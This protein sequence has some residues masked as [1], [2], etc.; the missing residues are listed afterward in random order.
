MIDT[1]AAIATPAGKGGVA[2]VRVSGPSAYTVAKALLNK[3]LKPRVATH[4]PFYAADG[5]LLDQGIAI[6]FKAPHSFT[7][8]EVVEFHG[9]GGVI[10]VQQVLNAIIAMAD[11]RMARPGEFSERAFLN[12]KIDLLQAESIAD[13]IDAHSTQAARCAMQSLQGVF[14]TEIKTLIAQLI[15]LRKWVE[16]SIDFSDEDL[17]LMALDQMQENI[18]DALVQLQRIMSAA[19]Q[20]SVLRNGIEMVLLGAPNVGKS[21]VLNAL[22]GKDVAIVTPVSGTTR[23]V[24]RDNIE[25]DGLLF[26]VNDTAGIR[27]TGD[28]IE[29]EG[30]RR[31][32]Q[33]VKKSDVILVMQDA[34]SPDDSFVSMEDLRRDG[35]TVIKVYNKI[36]LIGEGPRVEVKDSVTMVFISAK[37]GEGLDLL[38]IQLKKAAGGEGGQEATFMARTRHLESLRLAESYLQ[39]ALSQIISQTTIDMVAEELRCGQEALNQII[40]EGFTT[41]STDTIL[42]D[43]F[44]SF[45]VG[46]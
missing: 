8:E 11:V 23:D 34:T 38:K 44:S 15:E 5:L 21:S 32:W 24:I 28:M 6:Y 41:V 19:Q 18:Q 22:A 27:E 40:G 42:G 3:S 20:G 1:I 29:Q 43:I 4:T 10:V 12:G 14:S 45:C 35:Q 39:Q 30:I 9:H 13:L 46:K 16:A 17:D 33:E 37:T 2:I 31:S 36:D 25:L 7:G 26:H